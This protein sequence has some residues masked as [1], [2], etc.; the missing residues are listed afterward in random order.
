MGEEIM[1][2]GVGP[3]AELNLRVSVAA[4][5]RV[6]VDDPAGGETLLVLERA[7]TLRPGQGGPELFVRAKPYGGGV[8]LRDVEALRAA[9]GEFRFDSARSMQEADFRLLIRQADW[10]QVCRKT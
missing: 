1:K 7:A 10:P 5:A 2:I 3:T 4:L 8:R 6:V 9:I